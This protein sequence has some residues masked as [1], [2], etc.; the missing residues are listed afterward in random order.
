MEAEGLL[1][2]PLFGNPLPLNLT[3]LGSIVNHFGNLPAI[4]R[5]GWGL[6]LVD[7]LSV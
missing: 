6:S 7:T 3:E 1:S 2:F 5:W 4:Q